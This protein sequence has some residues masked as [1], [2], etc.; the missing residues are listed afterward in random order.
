MELVHA[1]ENAFLNKEVRWSLAV[2]GCVRKCYLGKG[3]FFLF[4]IFFLGLHLRHVEVPSLG[5]KSELQLPAYATAT[6][7]PDLS[8][9]CNL[10]N[11]SQT[12]QI[13]NQLSEA[14]VQTCN[15]MGTSWIHFH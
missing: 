6:A 11:S 9:I 14:R 1:A 15:L 4:L 10:H 8:L 7:K 3:F 13:L 5:V 12:T 2:C